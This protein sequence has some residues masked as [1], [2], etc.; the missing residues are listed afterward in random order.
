M[1]LTGVPELSVEVNNGKPCVSHVC[2]TNLFQQKMR[3]WQRHHLELVESL[4]SNSQLSLQAS[5]HVCLERQNTTQFIPAKSH[6]VHIHAGDEGHLL[7][8]LLDFFL[9]HYGNTSAIQRSLSSHCNNGDNSEKRKEVLRIKDRTLVLQG[10]K[11]FW[12]LDARQWVCN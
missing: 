8:W 10:K 7:K 1:G 9:L 11:E 12:R 2:Y 5:Q 3:E 6:D 4:G